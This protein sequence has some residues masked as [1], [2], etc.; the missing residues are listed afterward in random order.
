[1]KLR[2]VLAGFGTVG[3][4]LS[5]LLLER[6]RIPEGLEIS[7]VGISDMVKG[8]LYA[9]GGIDLAGALE[10]ATAGKKISE[11]GDGFD[12][13]ALQL[14]NFAGQ[15]HNAGSLV[16]GAEARLDVPPVVSLML[17]TAYSLVAIWVLRQRIRPVEVVV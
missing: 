5:E 10:R 6:E 1:M 8:S 9:P 3:Q 12:G 13:D 4:G 2:L 7:V 15:Y 17:T 16:F 14:I 11:G